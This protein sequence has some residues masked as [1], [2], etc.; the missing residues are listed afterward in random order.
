MGAL[1]V[2]FKHGIASLHLCREYLTKT[3]S[4]NSN[5]VLNVLMYG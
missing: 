2:H 4:L 1:Y 3:N 5:K